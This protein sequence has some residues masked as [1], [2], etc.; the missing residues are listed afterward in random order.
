[1]PRDNEDLRLGRK[2][3]EEEARVPTAINILPVL[4]HF[5]ATKLAIHI[6]IRS[7][8]AVCSVFG[9][10]HCLGTAP[11]LSAAFRFAA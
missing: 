10:L 9:L 4:R 1:M 6:V 2:E 5:L 7:R 3:K 8:T 11:S